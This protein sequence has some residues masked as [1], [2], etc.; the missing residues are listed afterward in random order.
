MYKSVVEICIIQAKENYSKILTMVSI[1]RC[2]FGDLYLKLMILILIPSPISTILKY[3]NIF[4]I[5]ITII[6]IY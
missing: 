1:Q 4:I 2:K 5:L 6:G 3:I